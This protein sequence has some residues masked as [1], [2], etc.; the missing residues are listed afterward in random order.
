MQSPPTVHACPCLALQAPVAS[1]VPAHRP[2]GS[3][4]PV[5]ATQVWLVVLHDMQLPGQSLLVQQPVVG[6][7]TVVDPLVHAFVDPV[8]A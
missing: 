6:M 1:Q 4:A 3:S 7:Q 8:H 2:F 5:T